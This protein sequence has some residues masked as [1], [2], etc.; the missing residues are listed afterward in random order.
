MKTTT[1]SLGALT[2]DGS[3]LT[4]AAAEPARPNLLFCW[5][6]DWGR[7]AGPPSFSF[8]RVGPNS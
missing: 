5:A 7:C 8:L 1:L 3:V 4:A 2:F 6:D